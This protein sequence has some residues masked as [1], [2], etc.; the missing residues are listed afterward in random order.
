M[1]NHR[2]LVSEWIATALQ[3]FNTPKKMLG[4]VKKL[5]RTRGVKSDLQSMYLFEDIS[6]F[7]PLFTPF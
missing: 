4:A 5:L 3:N 1:V 6:P 2:V 7:C